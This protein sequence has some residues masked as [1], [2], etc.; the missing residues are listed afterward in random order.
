[1]PRRILKKNPKKAIY[2]FWEG[3]SEEVYTKCIKE[4][5][6]KSATIYT[7]REK[8]TFSTAKAFYRGNTKFRENLPEYDEIWFFFDTELDKA[9]QWETNWEYLEEVLAAKHPHDFR[10]RLL[11]TSGCVEYWF[12]LHYE[13]VA[14]VIISPAD[15]GRVQEQLKTY[16]PTYQ[17]GDYQSTQ[18]IAEQYEKGIINGRWS[19]DRLIPDGLPQK[20]GKVRDPRDHWLYK[21]EHTFTTVHEAIEYLKKL[22][23]ML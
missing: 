11:M 22:P 5:F 1:M 23:K 12:L 4:T 10:I 14:P 18:M 17:K 13:K 19:L 8:G 20:R 3:E 2:V 9:N 16:V 6:S 7:H 15:K 21:G